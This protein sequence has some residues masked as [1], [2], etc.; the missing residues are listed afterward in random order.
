MYDIGYVV[1]IIVTAMT[2]LILLTGCGK[3][4]PT[5]T[6]LPATATRIALEAADTRLPP[7]ATPVSPQPP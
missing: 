4:V 6:L 7:S 2:V 3:S 5:A 1:R